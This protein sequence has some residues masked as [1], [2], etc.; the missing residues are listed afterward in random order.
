MQSDPQDAPGA[1]VPA[2][3]AAGEPTPA[4]EASAV[5]PD[6]GPGADPAPAAE[7][8]RRRNRRR[9]KGGAKAATPPGV[10]GEPAAA[11][12]PPRPQGERQ[13]RQA[14]Q[15]PSRG[16]AQ[17]QAR[18]RAEK[19][20]R[21]KPEREARAEGDKALAD[22]ADGGASGGEDHKLQKLL[23]EVGLGSR[24][25]MEEA[26]TAGRVSVNGKTATLGQRITRRDV[27]RVDSKPIRLKN[28]REAPEVL[29]YHKPPGQ[30]VSQD[31][32]EGRPTV[33]D[34]LP[35][36]KSGRWVAVGR[37]DFNTEGL[38]ILT[39][40][41]D[42][43]NRLMH[44]RY[45]IEREYSVRVVGEL[46]DEQTDSLLDGVELDD[47]P[48]RFMRLDE[49]EFSDEGPGVNRWYRVMIRE[50]RNREVRRMFEKVG[51]MVSRLIRTRFGPIP[52]PRGLRRGQARPLTA[53]EVKDLIK[54]APVTGAP[55]REMSDALAPGGGDG[56]VGIP[57]GVGGGRAK[58][59]GTPG[60]GRGNGNV[61]GNVK[62]KGR[63]E[64]VVGGILSGRPGGRGV[65]AV[66]RAQPAA[67][68]G[69]KPLAGGRG[70]AGKV[71]GVRR[72]AKRAGLD[73]GSLTLDGRRPARAGRR[74]EAYVPPPPPPPIITRRRSKLTIIPPE[75]STDV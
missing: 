18:G 4:Q 6:M 14:G 73:R 27:V 34:D 20:A 13:P 59:R 53:L 32:P 56:A 35:A 51:V 12:P 70:P 21:G 62:G 48:A 38:L 42:L 45:E 33:F 54:G 7:R 46:S 40:S 5:K 8:R 36:P 11:E 3:P 25:D 74:P 66:G 63:A 67:R 65:K 1:A 23:A 52:L 16:A 47:G 50:G 10:P 68:R 43:A 71:A 69:S 55:G 64:A 29:I 75:G 28:E 57:A 31:D 39:N 41:G 30:I 9:G 72:G 24:R 15:K 19:P 58:P 60:A 61:N 37:L 17:K 2:A 49:G 44:P 26:I 22:T